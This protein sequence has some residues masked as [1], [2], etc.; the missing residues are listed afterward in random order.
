MSFTSLL[1]D[2]STESAY[3]VLPFYVT[4]VLGFGK[5]VLGLIEGVGEFMASLFKLLSGWIA[6]RIRKYKVL[7]LIGY[8]LSTIT[9]PLLAFTSHWLHVLVVKAVDRVG[10]GVRTSPRD[11]LLSMSASSKTRGRAFGF[12][13]SMDTVGAVLGPFLA[14]LLL[15]LVG[16][17]GVFLFCFIPG[18]LAVLILW[19]FVREPKI[20]GPKT[21]PKQTREAT[22]I[23]GIPRSFWMFLTAL[24]LTGLAG[25]THAFLLIRATEIGWSQENAILLLTLANIVYAATAYPVGLLG[26]KIG[27]PK[28]Y[29][30]AFIIQALGALIVVYT[31]SYYWGLLYFIL[32][33]LYHG[34]NDTLMRVLTS[35]YVPREL[36]AKAYGYMHGTHGFTALTGYYIV[37]LLYE[38]IGVQTAFMYTTIIAL[39]GL[40]VST[41]LAVH[42][43]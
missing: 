32:Y 10:K 28:L 18:F 29:P 3:A 2:V 13:R 9:K 19:L 7:A 25:Y 12:H 41:Y 40:I 36:R 31:N 23:Q 6:D 8:G 26:D 43:K 20:T 1:T 37:G 5:D 21:L 17:K 4:A 30:M 38:N 27:H 34:F 39:I 24:G 16:F 33:G 15:P 22:S 14:F 35:Y 11:V 42:Q